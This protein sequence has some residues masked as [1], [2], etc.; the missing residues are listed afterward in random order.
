MS[1]RT[2]P[3]EALIAQKTDDVAVE[4]NVFAALPTIPNFTGPKKKC[5]GS[6]QSTFAHPISTLGTLA[7]ALGRH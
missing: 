7:E 5:R 6:L 2:L 4:V 1:T 3:I